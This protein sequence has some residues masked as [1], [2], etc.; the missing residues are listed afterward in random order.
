MN[1]LRLRL[2]FLILLVVMLIFQASDSALVVRAQNTTT[3]RITSFI[4]S[5]DYVN[6]EA[7]IGRRARVPVQWTTENRSITTNLA[8][9]QVFPD[10]TTINVELPRLFPWVNSNGDGMTAPTLAYTFDDP[11]QLRVRLYNFLTGETIDQKDLV[12]PIKQVTDTVE[13]NTG[14]PAIERFSPMQ[15]D[16]FR[17]DLVNGTARFPV[18][19]NVINRPVFATLIFEQVLS[20]NNVRNVELP[21]ESPWV[22][23][24]GQGM[25]APVIPLDSS[26]QY[27]VL[28]LSLYD[29]LFDRLMDQREIYVTIRDERPQPQFVQFAA[30]VS[31][32]NRQ[33]LE[34][35]TAL[36]PLVWNVSNRPDNVNIAF[37][38]IFADGSSRNI[39]LP[40][41]FVWVPSQGRGNVQPYAPNADESAIRIRARVFDVVSG[42]LRLQQDILLP[43]VTTDNEPVLEVFDSSECLTE[44]FLPGNGIEVTKIAEVTAIARENALDQSGALT[45]ANAPLNPIS[46]S[47]IF[48]GE[49]FTVVGGPFCY[50][51]LSDSTT[52]QK[53]FRKWRVIMHESGA[54]GWVSEFYNNDSSGINYNIQL[55]DEANNDNPR[56]TDVP[57]P[58]ATEEPTASNG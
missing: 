6:A 11:I 54:D 50:K 16:V 26:A 42:A 25:V 4:S 5:A 40:R 46:A 15:L 19:W 12:L 31:E 30:E 3:P 53:Q 29:V 57:A 21:R 18:S 47:T 51:L 32:V 43:V 14:V 7:L 36:V 35:R 34:N 55:V 58:E 17:D 1:T 33:Q 41:D 39:E 20:P 28:R 24:S 13:Q 52:A 49:R 38:Q 23:S 22:N 2:S 37:E 48:A 44:E 27:I 10:G 9:E 45:L 8:F 56:P